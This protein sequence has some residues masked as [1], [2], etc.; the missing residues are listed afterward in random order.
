MSD[1]TI[2]STQTICH[3]NDKKLVLVFDENQ[4]CYQLLAWH[5]C[6][7]SSNYKQQLIILV[8][9]SNWLGTLITTRENQS[10][11]W[12]N[13]LNHRQ[14]QLRLSE[15]IDSIITHFEIQETYDSVVRLKSIFFLHK[16][17]KYRYA[18]IV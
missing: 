6:Q 18:I 9:E 10:L 13:Y 4:H 3:N 8:K 12:N 2:S 5:H 16:I 1:T 15:Q 7:I 14:H 11:I 17:Y